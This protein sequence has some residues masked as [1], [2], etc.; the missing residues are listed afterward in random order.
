MYY[1]K[2]CKN[3]IDEKICDDCGQDTTTL[4]Y[5]VNEYQRIQKSFFDFMVIPD[6]IEINIYDYICADEKELSDTG[7]GVYLTKFYNDGSG[8]QIEI[9]D[10][11]SYFSY[12]DDAAKD[13]KDEDNEEE[14]D[15]DD[16]PERI[17]IPCQRTLSLQENL[18]NKIKLGANIETVNAAFFKIFPFITLDQIDVSSINNF[19]DMFSNLTIPSNLDLTGWDVSKG[20]DFSSM[21]SRVKIHGNLNLSGWKLSRVE[22][23][24]SMFKGAEIHGNLNLS[25]WK[26]SKA[27]T[28]SS[29]FEG[30]KIHGSLNIMDW[31]NS[32]VKNF[33]SMFEEA[34]ITSVIGLETL[35]TRGGLDFEDIF[36]DC[37]IPDYEE[38]IK[39]WKFNSKARYIEAITPVGKTNHPIQKEEVKVKLEIPPLGLHVEKFSI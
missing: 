32:K 10:F 22:D 38:K 30:V 14:E 18:P 1:C 37:K 16:E 15:E 35:D 26:L 21:F 29:M 11:V 39:S 6:D 20:E 24:S 3:L 2:Q 4:E 5:V 28:V 33:S 9:P 31:K 25:G 27:T 34:K 17:H 8:D 7:K 13:G 19:F 23:L 12:I 36:L